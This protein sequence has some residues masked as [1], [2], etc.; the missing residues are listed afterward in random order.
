MV[1]IRTLLLLCSFIS[2]STFAEI[3]KCKDSTGAI[4]MSD[5]PC[6]IGSD[7]ISVTKQ[8][9]L[10][11]NEAEVSKILAKLVQEKLANSTD[12]KTKEVSELL[13]KM[14]ALRVYAISRTFKPLIQGCGKVDT[15]LQIDMHN[16]YNSYFNSNNDLLQLGKAL[17]LKDIVMP[18]GTRVTASEME[19]GTQKKE[20]EISESFSQ[21]S[22]NNRP[23]LERQC[24]ESIRTLNT[25]R[26][27]SQ[28]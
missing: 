20:H 7:T 27:I 26:Q 19:R 12:Q 23:K 16:A 18:D 2:T 9:K 11:T 5:K 15:K 17:S 22:P 4:Q 1:T 6:D 3:Y 28:Q 14:E 25:M 13:I 10:S 24:I 8:D 21:V